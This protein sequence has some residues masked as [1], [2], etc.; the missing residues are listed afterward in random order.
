[1]RVT[2]MLEYANEAGQQFGYRYMKDAEDV[3][4]TCFYTSNVSAPRHILGTEPFDPTFRTYGW[5]DIDVGYRL[6]KRGVRLV[7]NRKAR[8]RH[9]HPME[10]SDFYRRQVKVGSAVSALYALHPELRDDQPLMPLP[11]RS[12]IGLTVG[13]HVVPLLVP[14]IN[15]LDC[16]MVRLPER[17]YRAVLSTGYW[18]GRG[19]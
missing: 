2:P 3:P 10:L 11:S 7:F 6:A 17:V 14:L 1:M 15:W 9:R 8:A 13:R 4:Y 18:I 16:H 19:R 5:E 12:H